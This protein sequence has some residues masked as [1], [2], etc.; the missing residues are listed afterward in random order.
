MKKEFIQ[1]GEIK[2]VGLTTRTNNHNEMNAATGK[3]GGVIN[4]FFSNQLASKI[5]D[6]KNPGVTLSVYTEYASDEH[7]E[8]TYFFG[9]EVSDFN[10]IPEGLQTLIIPTAQYQKFTTPAGK[11]PDIVIQA[12]QAIWK[13]TPED[14][15]GTR[16]Y[17]ADFEVYDQ[18]SQDPENAVV[19]IY[20]GIRK[21]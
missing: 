6:R 17:Q 20:I 11:M 18:R 12:W 1:R 8:Y 5:M 15:S 9:E 4:E 16:A 10:H 2:L 21:Y 3:I 14:F 13:M 7:G 19:D